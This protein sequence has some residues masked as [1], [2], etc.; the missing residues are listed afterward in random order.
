MSIK[1]MHD[2]HKLTK[3]MK[4]FREG[5]SEMSAVDP[6]NSENPFV[7]LAVENLEEKLDYWLEEVD[8]VPEASFDRGP[9]EYDSKKEMVLA[10]DTDGTLFSVAKDVEPQNAAAIAGL[11]N[12]I[13]ASY[14][15]WR[16]LETD[17]RIK[18]GLLDDLTVALRK[19]GVDVPIRK[20]V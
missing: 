5:L 2:R 3:A 11:P 9:W 8:K 14:T 18:D 12:L 13:Y 4:K 17:P 19:A 15:L 6:D 20:T 16:L 7:K 10:T 1:A